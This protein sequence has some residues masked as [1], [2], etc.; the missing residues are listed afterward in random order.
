[1]TDW[2]GGVVILDDDPTGTQSA[3]GVE[4][5]LNLD[6]D[7]LRD[8][9]ES[10]GPQPVYVLTNNRALTEDDALRRT[11][12]ISAIARAAWPQ[13]QIVCRGDSTLRGHL[14]PEF[15]GVTEHD[16]G[17]GHVL[18][19][20]PAM[21]SAGR[22]TLNG[23]HF[24]ATDQSLVPVAGTEYARDAEFG[25]TSSDVLAWAEERSAAAFRAADGAIV[26]LDTLRSE[27]PAAV[28][29]A[30]KLL[31][32]HARRAACVCDAET[33]RD[34]SLVAD[35]VRLAWEAGIAVT[36]RCAPPLAAML[37]D[38]KASG[39]CR[40]PSGVGRLLLVVGSYV[41]ASTSQLAVIQRRHPG[42]VVEARIEDL[43]AGSERESARLAGML[44]ALWE[45]GPLAVLATPRGRPTAGT[46]GLAVARG[47]A[48]AVAGL[49]VPPEAVVTRG[50]VTSAVTAR[51]GLAASSAWSC[52]PVRPGIALWN[53][54][55]GPATI[56]L[57]IAAGNIGG[58]NDLADLLEEM[59]A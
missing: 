58:P 59:V 31:A 55:S 44:A 9:F 18:L 17:G 33:E 36:V 24:L 34:L 46:S 38:R 49:P 26:A 5:L 13:A 56:P 20:V 54:S 25:Y 14:L 27:G 57:L 22:V 4:V 48:R 51:Y 39:F 2:P 29:Q 28:A 41:Q 21:P 16:N 15:Q 12:G 50:G 8:W 43:A 19:I 7:Y 11:S 3:A 52:G 53:V 10:H 37:A 23:T 45:N 47:M 6:D 35:G 40:P 32:L 42:R 1:V 30:V